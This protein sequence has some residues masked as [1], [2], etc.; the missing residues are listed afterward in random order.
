M[1]EARQSI[2]AQTQEIRN[3]IDEKLKTASAQRDENI[4]K[5]L[6]RLHEHVRTYFFYS[7]NCLHEH[8]FTYSL[9]R[10]SYP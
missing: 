10:I 4:K 2:E 6:N 8:G 5:I 1:E 9:R 3:A 7:K